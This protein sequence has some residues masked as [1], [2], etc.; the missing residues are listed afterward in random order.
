[1]NTPLY[2]IGLLF[3]VLWCSVSSC[4]DA[5]NT[6]Q[7]TT[8]TTE[9]VVS[10]DK[11]Y[12]PSVL[13]GTQLGQPRTAVLAARPKAN[14]VNTLVE[15]PYESFTENSALEDYTSIYYDFE[16]V[17]PQNLV[18]LRLMHTNMDALK[19]SIEIFGGKLVDNN[20]A[21]YERVLNEQS[22]VRAK[23]TNRTILYYLKEHE[24]VF[25]KTREH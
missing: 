10:E 5:K 14:R 8:E 15:T 2:Q 7:T 18:R 3:I 19:A 13:S 23:V 16:R 25:S 20:Q 21:I 22:T 6:A 17:E 24:P 12:L 9:T 11:P 1:M 4:Q